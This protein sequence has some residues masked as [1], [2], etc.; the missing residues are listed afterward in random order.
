MR[1][2]DRL[3]A[4]EDDAAGGEQ[5]DDG[6]V[7]EAA[8][9]SLVGFALLLT[10]VSLGLCVF[11][12]FEHAGPTRSQ[13]AIDDLPRQHLRPTSPERARPG[14]PRRVLGRPRAQRSLVDPS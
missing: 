1:T 12:A 6:G 9:G 4:G 11:S 7:V 8:V 13:E 3:V 2:S 10:A 14:A 5:R